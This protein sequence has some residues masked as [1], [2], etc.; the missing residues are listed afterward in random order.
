MRP[1]R[2][3]AGRKK[4][5]RRALPLAD[6]A[7]QCRTFTGR[8]F[9]S[10]ASGTRRTRSSRWCRS[11]RRRCATSCTSGL[12]V[13]CRKSSWTDP[14]HRPRMLRRR[15]GI[16]R[17]ARDR[18]VSRLQRQRR[19]AQELDRPPP[20]QIR[21]APTRGSAWEES[22]W[23]YEYSVDTAVAP[24]IVWRYWSD[25]T[26]WPQWNNGIE[27]LQIDGPFAVGT[28]MQMTP[29]GEN[30]ITLRLVD[31]VPGEL[32]TDEMD[33]GD[34]TVRTLHRLEQT[35]AGMTR[36]I[37]RTEITGSAADLVGPQLGPAITADFPDVLAA[38]VRVAESADG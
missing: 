19:S 1:H 23:E 2:A 21:S 4:H 7:R 36:I 16:R 13:K 3:P 26:A 6:R 20:V 14:C 12:P 17:T 8:T 15:A 27:K 30:P 33:A 28:T 18:A 35:A 32:F 5:R 9:P 11:V 10:A 34:F 24:D 38:L 29:P 37:Y 25:P 31:I 22:M